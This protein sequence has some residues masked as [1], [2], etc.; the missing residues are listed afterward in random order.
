MSLDG[1]SARNSL[2]L[3][4]ISMVVTSGFE[5]A[6]AKRTQRR[7]RT[8]PGLRRLTLGQICSYSPATSRLGHSPRISLLRRDVR[9]HPVSDQ[10]VDIAP[11]QQSASNGHCYRGG[12]PKSV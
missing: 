12:S 3:I 1:S 5:I 11:R 9:F 6:K 10:I 4:T 7:G 2:N 8:G